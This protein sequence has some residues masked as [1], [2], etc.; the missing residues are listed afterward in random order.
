MPRGRAVAALSLAGGAGAASWCV[1]DQRTMHGM[2]KLSPWCASESALRLHNIALPNG[3]RTLTVDTLRSFDGRG[4]PTTLFA[5]GGVVYDVTGEEVFA[6]GGCY[7][8]F[9]GRDATYCLARMSLDARDVGRRN[10]T[11]DASA[12]A[13]LDD[14]RA[15]FDQ[16]Y[17]RAGRLVEC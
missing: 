8:Q 14:W 11:L 4:K 5:V 17:R 16:K 2:R 15:Y 1:Y 13:T 12:Q 10:F 9:S 7:S 3:W 6:P